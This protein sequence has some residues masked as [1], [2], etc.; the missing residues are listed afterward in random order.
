[1]YSKSSKPA[2]TLAEIAAGLGL[3]VKGGGDPNCII[4]GVGS[5]VNAK[6]GQISFLHKKRW[7]KYLPV[8]QASAVILTAEHLAECPVAAIVTKDPYFTYAK[9]AE[10][11]VTYPV[12][13][14]IH[15]S[16]DIGA[17]CQIAD[18]VSIAAGTVIEEEVSIAAGTII[19]PNC[20]IGRGSTIGENCQLW[21]N[22]T[23]YPNSVLGCRVV[24]HSGA[25][26]GSDGFGIAFHAQR[27]HKVPQLGKVIIGDDVEIGANTTID[28]GALDD[29]RLGNGVKVDNQVHIAHN[30]IIGDHTAIAGCVGIAGGV[31]IGR[32]CMIAGGVGI[33][34]Y[35]DIV[36]NV[37]IT[38]MSLVSK[39]ITQPGVYSSGTVL[40][41]NI[42]WR[43]NAVRFR[44]LDELAR[45]L[46]TLEEIILKEKQT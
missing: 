33:A 36:D 31:N 43:K 15:P 20:S 10:L 29:T 38:G 6:A 24:I 32:Y 37:T 46:K 30:V 27:W 12:A 25:V 17:N 39:S 4:T 8:T 1:M 21:A 16:A 41:T 40:D 13:V 42:N 19:G 34:G 3:E 45:K 22:T 26:I 5:L 35:I 11:F 9:I 2:Y 7:E 14:G 23:L 18:D 28:R 44:Q